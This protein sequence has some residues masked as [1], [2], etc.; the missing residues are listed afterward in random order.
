M[1]SIT[2]GEVT[3]T[4]ITEWEGCAPITAQ[5]APEGGREVW[6]RHSSWLAPRFWN[7]ESNEVVTCSAS[8]LVRSAGKNILID[9]E[10]GNGKERPYFPL[11]SHLDTPYI[12]DLGRAGVKP[13]DVDIVV[14][15]HLHFDHV[16]WNTVLKNREWI[17]TFANATYLFT[18]EDFDYWNPLNDTK[19]LGAL[20]NQNAYEDSIAP[21]HNAG[22]AVL[23]TGSHTIDE[24]L[25]LV[26]APGHTPGSAIVNLQSGSDRA[27]FIGDVMNNP[28]Q[29]V[30]PH[31]NSCFCED[32][33]QARRTRHEVLSR[34]ADTNTLIFANHFAGGHAAEIGRDGDRF[35]ITRWS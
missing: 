4:R 7:R 26:A 9:A 11:S 24:N 15:T 17:P 2:L 8:Y 5:L 30:E 14:C 29:I 31:W 19:P 13:E 35:R 3:V 20:V 28:I 16:G 23:W 21:I 12:Q 33:Q 25:T 32:P 1:R 27:T 10:S 22:Q 18:S 6:E 34:A